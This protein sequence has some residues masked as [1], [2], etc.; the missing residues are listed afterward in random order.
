LKLEKHINYPELK[1]LFSAPDGRDSPNK[2]LQLQEFYTDIENSREEEPE[3]YSEPKSQNL[4]E[5]RDSSS[6]RDTNV[7][8]LFLFFLKKKHL[9]RAFRN[10]FVEPPKTSLLDPTDPSS[11]S[12]SSI[13]PSLQT[14]LHR[15][16]YTPL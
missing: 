7:I 8:L 3:D 10:F 13:P 2:V 15:I 4:I 12:F 5:P 16:H 14:L 6:R 9:R 11:S 1:I